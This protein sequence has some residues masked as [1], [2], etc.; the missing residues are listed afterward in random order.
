MEWGNR[1]INVV[2]RENISKFSKL[3]DIVTP[4]RLLEVFFDDVLVDTPGFTAIE[5][6]RLFLSMLLLSGS[7]YCLVGASNYYTSYYSSMLGSISFQ[8]L[9]CIG[10]QLG[11]SIFVTMNNFINKTNSRSSFPW[12]ISQTGDFQS[13][14]STRRTNPSH[15]SL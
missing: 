11:I 6:I 4:F 13:F 14:L 3:D 8:T 1:D 2:E 5:K 10:K 15:D 12:L 7:C 9:K